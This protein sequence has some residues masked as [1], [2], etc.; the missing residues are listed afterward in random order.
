MT[1]VNAP[2]STSIA[3]GGTGP[4]AVDAI[5]FST[6][7]VSAATASV[8]G[9]TDVEVFFDEVL[10]DCAVPEFE[11]PVAPDVPDEFVP[12]LFDTFWTT[13]VVVEVGDD[14]V[15]TPPVGESFHRTALIHPDVQPVA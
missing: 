5:G 4:A 9:T 14:S 2:V 8:A 3:F 12:L 1:A 13:V 10:V 7:F 6:T 11:E 15:G